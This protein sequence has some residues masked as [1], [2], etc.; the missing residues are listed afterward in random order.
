MSFDPARLRGNPHAEVMIVEFSDFQC[1][2]CRK[3]QPTLKNLLTKYEGHVS[4][5]YRDF[6]LRGMHGQAELGA[7]S[8]RC[9]GEQGKFWEYHDLLFQNPDKLKR[10]GLMELARDL[11]LDEKQF[12]DCLSG[13]KYRTKVEEDLQQGIRA[14]V[15]GTPG[16]FINGILLNGAQPEAVFERIIDS[17]LATAKERRGGP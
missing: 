6:P 5:A 15:L 2:F 10:N 1:P 3:V 17:E 9:A 4:L 8:A 13:G 11:K 16:I 14:G 12:D 7:E